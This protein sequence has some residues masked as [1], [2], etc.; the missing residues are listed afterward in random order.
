MV[1]QIVHCR[2]QIKMLELLLQKLFERQNIT[3]S[4]HVHEVKECQILGIDAPKGLDLSA[5][6]EYASQAA[7]W[8]IEVSILVLLH[9]LGHNLHLSRDAS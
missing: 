8:G 1:A 9:Y 3:W 2:Y 4:Q 5:N 6:T 7:L